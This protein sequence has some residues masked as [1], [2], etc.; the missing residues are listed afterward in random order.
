LFDAEVG[1]GLKTAARSGSRVDGRRDD[2]GSFVFCFRGGSAGVGRFG[3]ADGRP[4]RTLRFRLEGSS[5]LFDDC[6]E[7][8]RVSKGFKSR[9][10]SRKKGVPGL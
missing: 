7:E 6:F 4:G 10:K 9:R 8:E 3:V 2:V 1:R 5:T